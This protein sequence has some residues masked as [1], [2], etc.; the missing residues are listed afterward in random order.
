LSPST[1]AT[2]DRVRWP[3]NVGSVVPNPFPTASMSG[4]FDVPGSNRNNEVTS[5][6]LV[7][8]RLI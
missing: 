4:M 6:P 3:E 1:V 8:I 2:V 7:E 5:R